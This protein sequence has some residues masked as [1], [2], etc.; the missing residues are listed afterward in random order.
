M[1]WRNLDSRYTDRVTQLASLSAHELLGVEA[2]CTDAELKR[3]YLERIRSYH[4]DRA[5]PFM[6]ATNQE[7][8]KLINAA[9]DRLKAGK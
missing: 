6:Q 1:K 9:Y 3:A 5:D 7:I 8:V 2:E 4:P